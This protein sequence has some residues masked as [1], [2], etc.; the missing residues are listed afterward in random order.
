M[1][2]YFADG[3]DSGLSKFTTSG[4]VTWNPTAGVYGGGAIQISSGGDYASFV[5]RVFTPTGDTSNPVTRISF[6]MRTNATVTTESF[7]YQT[8]QFQ[9]VSSDYAF[10][11]VFT[12][13]KITS[14]QWDN[15]FHATAPRPTAY[16]RLD[17]SQWHHIELRLKYA[18]AGAYGIFVDGVYNYSFSTD[19]SGAGSDATLLDTFTLYN[20]RNGTVWY[21]DIMM[22]SET[23]TGDNFNGY[24]GPT[25]IFTFRPA[26]DT[27][28]ANSVPSSGSDRYLMLN[29]PTL[30]TAN[31]V[32][33]STGGK[34]FY[35]MA[36]IANV[37]GSI[38]GAQATL[39]FNSAD[40]G[41]TANL[42]PLLLSNNVILPGN[43]AKS[44]TRTPQEITIRFNKDF[45]SSNVNWT[46]STI[47]DLQIGF[48]NTG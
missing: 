4:S 43:T 26:A 45:G 42:R 21:D 44:V 20:F 18:N 14:W 37:G 41:Y 36:N 33:L 2:L 47:N 11:S 48:E 8:R 23:N 9:G 25:R 28:Q 31:Y 27:L 6:W 32:T 10:G 7:F 24:L 5:Q 40:T 13:G 12:D 17:D 38:Y 46:E 39:F 30:N 19:M 22:W 15:G 16:P 29:E 35:E 34:D 3:L 1:S